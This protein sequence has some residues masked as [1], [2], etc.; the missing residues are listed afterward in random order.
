MAMHGKH[1]QWGLRV[2]RVREDVRSYQVTSETVQGEA[3]QVTSEVQ[4]TTYE[5]KMKPQCA[6][7]GC[8]DMGQ[9]HQAQEHGACM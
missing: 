3:Y 8:L 7:Q 5:G 2:T 9:I 4:G 1:I 6:S